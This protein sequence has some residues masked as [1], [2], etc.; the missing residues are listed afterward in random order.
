MR[1]YSEGM[2]A[3]AAQV[4]EEKLI[5]E[6]V[7]EVPLPEGVKFLRVEQIVDSTGDPSLRL[8]F[9]VSKRRPQTPKAIREMNVALRRV[10]QNVLNL[11]LTKF[12]YYKLQE[13]R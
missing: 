6:K 12:P 8:Y 13:T 7:A 4:E 10:Q 3:P 11:G 1:A 9:S 2:I 5:L